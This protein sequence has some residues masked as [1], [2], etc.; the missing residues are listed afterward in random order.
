MNTATSTSV[1][2][3][4]LLPLAT[5]VILTACGGGN[6]SSPVTSTPPRDVTNNDDVTET[7]APVETARLSVTGKV[8][9]VGYVANAQV[10]FD[11]NDNMTCDNGEPATRSDAQGGYVLEVPTG[12][13]GTSLLAVIRPDATDSRYTTT[14]ADTPAILQGW[15][16]AMP[17]EYT[18][19]STTVER[20]I[21][22]L[23]SVYTSRM[24]SNGR[25]RLSNKNALL[26]RSG[27][28]SDYSLGA[29]YDY[30][31]LAPAGL[32]TQLM[33]LVDFLSARA[34]A[35]G[36]PAAL[37]DTMAVMSAWYG[38]YN[39]ST[40]PIMDI[41]KIN[42]TTLTNAIDT[43]G[44]RYFH[45][46]SEAAAQLRGLLAD[47]A[48]WMREGDTLVSL[49]SQGLRLAGGKILQ[50][51][52][53]WQ[54]GV[55]TAVSYPDAEFITT[56]SD[57]SL[58]VTEGNDALQPR[59]IVA[60]DGNLLA[61]RMPGT[62]VRYQIE[63]A[64][65]VMSNYYLEDWLGPQINATLFGYTEAPATQPACASS[66]TQTTASAWFNACRS[67][68]A[69]EYLESRGGVKTVQDSQA[70]AEYYDLTQL[71]ALLKI[72]LQHPLAA[73]QDC[74]AAG[75]VSVNLLGHET[76]NWM[77]DAG[78]S[79]TLDELFSD[80]GVLIDSWT[81]TN[82]NSTPASV[83]RQPL[84]LKLSGDGTGTL[85]GIATSNVTALS[86]VRDV[87]P[88]TETIVWQRH[89]QNASIILVGW[90]HNAADQ[91][92]P[93]HFS[94]T[95]FSVPAPT[96]AAPHGR[97]LAITVQDGVFLIGQYLPAGNSV[98]Y[99]YFNRAGLTLAID[100]LANEIDRLFNEA[101]FR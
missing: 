54:N 20:N 4:R 6:S 72:P 73:Y 53:Q 26:T 24:M 29:D 32:E 70:R 45:L 101:G 56:A 85:S 55:W 35:A 62:G 60:T 87:T 7:P 8:L 96:D 84:T 16:W 12:K 89:P 1:F 18:P 23:T 66:T 77:G 43:Y 28:L 17:L 25:N 68:F 3:A 2:R 69:D 97:K 33:A 79:H 40:A 67:L 78:T 61:F 47:N 14:A 13:R 21:S 38:S 31:Q 42:P 36:A 49:T 88:I 76:C 94:I 39:A 75:R 82:A 63:L 90:P 30:V 59:D 9:Q 44:Y 48:G 64:S 92:L 15:T 58:K 11:T 95:G 46:A 10:C 65:D 93:G 57:G 50:T 81:L 5:A 27:M 22:P 91:A 37:T 71:D 99:R 19:G 80:A 34:D 51:Y 41:S 83:P 86:I 98:S 74:E 52:E 100:L